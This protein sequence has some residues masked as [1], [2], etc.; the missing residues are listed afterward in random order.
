VNAFIA[1]IRLAWRTNHT[2]D[3]YQL[4][5]DNITMLCPQSNKKEKKNQNVN[6][7]VQNR[8]NNEAFSL[9]LG[10]KQHLMEN[11]CQEKEPYC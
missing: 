2:I 6:C 8:I 1:V 10:L 9:L 11:N 5:I 4:K 3:Y 7:L